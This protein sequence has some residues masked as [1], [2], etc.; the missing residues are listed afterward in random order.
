ML[1][2][3]Y[4]VGLFIGTQI[5]KGNERNKNFYYHH[6]DKII[7]LEMKIKEDERLLGKMN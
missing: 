2:F 3:H 6:T 7:N 4:I 1:L 5:G